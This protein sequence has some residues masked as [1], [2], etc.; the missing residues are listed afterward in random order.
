MTNAVLSELDTLPLVA[1][2]RGLR[3]DEAVDV[4]EAIVAAGFRCLEVPLNSPD[5]LVSIR[6]LRDA[7][8]GRAVVRAGPVLTRDAVHAVAAAGSQLVISPNTD[9]DV[10]RAAKAAGLISMPGFYTPSEAFAALAAGADVL[11][12]F[13]ASMQAWRDAG[14]RPASASARPSTNPDT[15]PQKPRTPPAHSSAPGRPSRSASQDPSSPTPD[16]ALRR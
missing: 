11:K 1:I 8:D 9:E 10:I 14:A 12:L 2:L 7:L 5:P 4:G 15:R 13:P 6:K 16:T 3:P